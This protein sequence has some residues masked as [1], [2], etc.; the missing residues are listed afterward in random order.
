MA[1]EF[2]DLYAEHTE[3][4]KSFYYMVFLTYL[5]AIIANVTLDSAIHPQPRLYLVL[6]GKSAD[7]RKSTALR[8]TDQFFREALISILVLH[9]AG[10]AEGLAEA[11][12]KQENGQKILV[13]HYDELKAFV[14]KARI[15][16]S[17]L[18][19][20]VTTLF[21]RNHYQNA[22]RNK[23]I[24]ISNA[25]LSLVS[26]CTPETY[27]SMFD[28]RFFAIGFLNRLFLVLGEGKRRFHLPP[29]IPDEQKMQIADKLKILL[30]DLRAV[31]YGAEGVLKLRLSPQADEALRNWYLN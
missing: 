27:A 19:P 2:A 4:P 25:H 1:A 5:G 24:E 17:V 22:V 28:S 11:F 12:S 13:L 8:L 6:L 23:N 15:E 3:A 7:T 31:A 9:G 21:E 30:Q 29:P 16:G 14:D 20:T 26:A 18:L 10:S